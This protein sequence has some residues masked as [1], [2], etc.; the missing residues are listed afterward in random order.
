M[1]IVIHIG[2][3]K[4]FKRRIGYRIDYCDT[5]E[6]YTQCDSI[7]HWV[8]LHVMWIPILPVGIGHD[9]VCRACKKPP[10]IVDALTSIV[11]AV[12]GIAVFGG[13]SLGVPALFL[14]M[15][16]QEKSDFSGGIVP[17]FLIAAFFSGVVAVYLVFR[18]RSLLRYKEAIR[19]AR[20]TAQSYTI[21]TCLDC[22]VALEPKPHLHCPHCGMRVF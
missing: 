4:L 14:W 11:V 6:D 17:A 13:V 18:L 10:R 15:L 20:E 1:P 8:V 16:T 19:R 3:Y 21:D 9:W 7:R 12:L 2:T 5:C 22:G